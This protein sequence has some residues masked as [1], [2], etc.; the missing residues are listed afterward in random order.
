MNKKGLNKI[1]TI[2]IG[3][4]SGVSG[5]IL[6]SFGASLSNSLLLRTGIVLTTL[7]GWIISWSK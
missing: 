5:I 1:Q 4:V 7:G 6:M 2:G 3:A